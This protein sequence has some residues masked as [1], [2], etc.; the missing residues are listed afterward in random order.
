MKNY[1]ENFI[2]KS[3]EKFGNKYDYSKVNYVNSTTPVIIVCPIHGEIKMSPKSHLNSTTGCKECSKH[4]THKKKTLI[5]NQD[6]KQM[7][8][9]RIWKALRTRATN[10]N[11]SSSIYY[12]NKGIKVCDR[13]NSFENFYNDMGKC[14]E[15]YSIDRIDPNKDYCPENCRWASY[16]TQSKNRGS[17]NKIFTY[18]GKSMVLK[19]WARE[20]G[21]KYTTLYMRIY[22]SGKSFEEAIQEDPFNKLIE[23]NGEKHT[24]SEWC[25]LKNMKYDIVCNRINKHKWTF[26]EAITIPKG[27]RRKQNKK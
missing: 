15:N 19:D 6:R 2:Q 21:I 4:V 18:K 8:E 14:P 9:Y 10:P 20:L 22:R 12:F 23:Y 24:L 11:T 16:S 26:E 17:F 25:I 13:W 1:K 3:K 27:V 5:D 7:K